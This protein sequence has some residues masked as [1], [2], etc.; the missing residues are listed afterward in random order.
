M[1]ITA[2]RVKT[3]DD[4]DFVN[5]YVYTHNNPD[6]PHDPSD[7]FEMPMTLEASYEETRAGGNLVL[8]AVD[9]VC[10][11]DTTPERLYSWLREYAVTSSQLEESPPFV[12]PAPP[13]ALRLWVQPQL[14]SDW[15]Q[16][17]LDLLRHILLPSVE[18]A[19]EPS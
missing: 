9:L 12:W 13:V 1:L 4:G 11:N 7:A 8:G 17:M 16:V 18:A 5:V 14:L 2:Q 10:P 19:S 15:N 3:T 6:W